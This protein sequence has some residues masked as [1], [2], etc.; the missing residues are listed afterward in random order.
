M[1]TILFNPLST[2]FTITDLDIKTIADILKSDVVLFDNATDDDFKNAE[3]IVCFNTNLGYSATCPEQYRGLVDSAKKRYTYKRDKNVVLVHEDENLKSEIIQ[4]PVKK[5]MLA[6]PCH[7]HIEVQTIKSID[8]LIVG[9]DV[10]CAIEIAKGYTVA[11]ARN[12]LVKRAIRDNY[13]YVFW[14]DA[15]MVLPPMILCRLLAM[16]SDLATGWYVKKIPDLQDGVTELL[17]PD[18]L[19][20]L[21]MTNIR[22]SELTNAPGIIDILG[23]GLGCSLMKTSALKKLSEDGK[24]PFVYVVNSDKSICSEDLYM[25]INMRKLGMTLKADPTQRCGHVGEYIY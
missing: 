15:D 9:D 12:E 25:C 21:P 23:C 6:I 8:N 16:D 13:D 14:I 5:V 4:K 19:Q 18:K 11:T 2:L 24:Q 22:E 3:S 17:G 20:Q 7:S 1:K 10:E